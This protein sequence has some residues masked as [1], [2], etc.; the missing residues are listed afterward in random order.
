VAEASELRAGRR[1]VQVAEKGRIALGSVLARGRREFAAAERKREEDMVADDKDTAMPFILLLLPL[2]V[3]AVFCRFPR[4]GPRSIAILV[5]G[6][7]GRSPRMMYHAQS[8]AQHGFHTH[9]IGYGGPLPFTLR[10]PRCATHFRLRRH[11][12]QAY[13]SVR[14]SPH[15]SP[16]PPT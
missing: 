6:D 10:V 7:I 14:M 13:S 2:A 5:L 12:L 4:H 9:L 8:F 3:L 15:T 1:P 16:A 11:R